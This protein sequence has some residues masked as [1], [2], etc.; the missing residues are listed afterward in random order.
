[1]VGNNTVVHSTSCHGTSVVR[2]VWGLIG[3]GMAL[4]DGLGASADRRE[5]S[6]TMEL[7]PGSEIEE[8][9]G[10]GAGGTGVSNGAYA[11]S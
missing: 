8:E 4:P 5:A 7:F 11:E 10:S 3:V 6:E 9:A 2:V 1:M